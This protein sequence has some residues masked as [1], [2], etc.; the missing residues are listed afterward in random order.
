[1]AQQSSPGSRTRWG[2]LATGYIAATFVEDLRLLPDAEVVAV[3]SRTEETARAFADR[4]GVPRAYGSWQEFAADDDI[5]VVYVATPHAAHFDATMAC[6]DAGRAVLVEKPITLDRAAAQ[7][8]VDVATAND[9]FLME[10]MWMRCNP[11][12]LRILELIADGAI[13]EVTSVQADFGVGGPFP[14]EHR[15]R[16]RALG[17]GA[18]LDLGV[19]PISLAHLL[20]GLPDQVRSWAK[21]S[22][23]GV[24]ENTGVILGYDSGA[25]ATLSCG[26]IGAT[27]AAAAITGRTGRIELAPPFYRSGQVTLLRDGADPELLPVD[28]AGSGYQHEAAEVQRCLAAGLLESPL[29]P[30][31]ATLEV[32]GLLDDIRE[33]IGVT[34][35]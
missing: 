4:H 23:E 14:P 10:A 7:R 12:V 17:G 20:L 5:D 21:I 24:D 1:M 3:G 35:P 22:P 15:M 2:I 18:L 27:R 31:A 19:Y 25:V 28:L 16:A 26:M 34:Y 8:L 30:H 33:Q 11:V 9:R 13:G 29:V 6:L 32:M